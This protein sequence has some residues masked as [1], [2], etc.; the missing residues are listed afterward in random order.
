MRSNRQTKSRKH[1]I[2]IPVA[3]VVLLGLIIFVFIS[4]TKKGDKAEAEVPTYKITAQSKSLFKGTVTSEHTDDYM[5]DASL[6]TMPTIEVKT[7]QEVTAGQAILTYKAK[8]SD[9]TSLSYTVKSAQLALS[10]AQDNLL[11]AQQQSSSLQDKYK[12]AVADKDSSTSISATESSI[13]DPSAI[14]AQISSNADALQQQTYA[15]QT[16]QLSLEQ[17]QA[18]FTEAE[19]GEAQS[20]SSSNG[21]PPADLTSLDYAVKQAQLA[22]T[23]AQDTLTKLRSQASSLQDQYKQALEDQKTAQSNKA[24][25][26]NAQDPSAVQA[27]IDSNTQSIQQLTQTVASNSLAVQAA[28]ANLN[29]AQRTGKVTVKAKNAGI[30]KVGTPDDATKPLVSIS[31]KGTIITGQISEFDYSKLK[32]GDKVEIKAINLQQKTSGVVSVISATPTNA[33]NPAQASGGTPAASDS[34][35]YYTFTIT[36]SKNLQLGYNVQISAQDDVLLIP[37]TAMKEGYVEV[38][39]GSKFVKTAVKAKPVAKGQLQV[40]SGL[41]AGD[42]ISQ[43]GAAQ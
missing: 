16:A 7:A 6:G 9:L 11:I 17:A 4:L 3:S 41:K 14:Q 39:K 5:L 30:A 12:Q 13:S 34:A 36:P 20:V 42:V 23:Q 32:V 22:L 40:L 8:D 37:K 15:V 43:N 2:I 31:T 27:E 10:Q 29:E 35:S 26:A 38:K 1:L 33:A 28:Q 24:K 21:N 19:S 25:L 18:T